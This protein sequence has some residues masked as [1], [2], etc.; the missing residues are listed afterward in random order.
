MF[1]LEF[2]KQQTAGSIDSDSETVTV[3]AANAALTRGE[4]L[5]AAY[6]ANRISTC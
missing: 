3:L 6:P 1:N 4:L 5:K 2:L